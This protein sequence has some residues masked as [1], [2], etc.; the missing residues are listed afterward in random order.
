M[1]V[2]IITNEKDAFI[3][4]TNNENDDSKINIKYLF[5]SLLGTILLLSPIG[6]IYW[7][8]TRPSITG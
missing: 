4:C 2:I 3:N 5:L 7:S 1:Y 6:L 8:R